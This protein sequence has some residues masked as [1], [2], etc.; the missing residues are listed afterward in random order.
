MAEWHKH[1]VGKNPHRYNLVFFR[2]CLQCSHIEKCSLTQKPARLTTPEPLACGDK[3]CWTRSTPSQ[4]QAS[5]F[6]Y[7]IRYITYHHIY[8]RFC[9]EN[10]IFV[11][12]WWCVQEF[13]ITFIYFLD[14]VISIIKVYISVITIEW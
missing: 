5:T 2:L 14:S 4:P 10:N 9:V 13:V 12:V 6:K 1:L 3:P 8:R 11:M 7:D